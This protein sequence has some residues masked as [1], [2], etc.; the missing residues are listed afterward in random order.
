MKHLSER[1]GAFSLEKD[2]G[3]ADFCTEVYGR[4]SS[5]ERNGCFHNYFY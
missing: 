5:K 3:C 2:V 4:I 1:V